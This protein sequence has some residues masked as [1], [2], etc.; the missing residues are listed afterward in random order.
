MLT[1]TLKLILFEVERKYQYEE[2]EN[3]VYGSVGCS[4]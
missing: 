1:V 4:S 2:V 3:D